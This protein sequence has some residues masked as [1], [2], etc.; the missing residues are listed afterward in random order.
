M[1]RRIGEIAMTGAS[2]AERLYLASPEGKRAAERAAKEQLKSECAEKLLDW[3]LR[4]RRR[5][6]L[7]PSA[8]QSGLRRNSLRPPA[9]PRRLRGYGRR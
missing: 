4:A 8:L 9:R 5:S 1:G 6:S 2:Y 3:P 7:S